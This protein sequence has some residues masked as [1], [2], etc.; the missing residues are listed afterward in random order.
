[1]AN[2]FLLNEKLIFLLTSLIIITLGHF[3]CSDENSNPNNDC[4]DTFEGPF[5]DNRDSKIYSTVKIGDQLWMAENLNYDAGNGSWVYNDIESNAEI[6]GR[7]YNWEI[8]LDACPD[9]WHLPSE[10][11]WQVLFDFL[12]GGGVAG[13]RM[14]TIDTTYWESPNRSNKFKRIIGFTWW[15]MVQ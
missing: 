15:I 5:S 8:T 3:S 13:G 14:K 10:E 4:E 6:Y 11:E 7:L 2:Y 9:C 1:L 12:G